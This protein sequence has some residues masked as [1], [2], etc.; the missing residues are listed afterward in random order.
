MQG[1]LGDG[2]QGASLAAGG[3]R[4]ERPSH[5]E[6]LVAVR[7]RDE[8][9]RHLEHH[10][11]FAHLGRVVHVHPR[12]RPAVRPLRSRVASRAARLRRA[13]PG[14]A[15]AG[16]ARC[17]RAGAR[18]LEEA[19]R[20]RRGQYRGAVPAL[21]VGRDE[22]RPRASPRSCRPQRRSSRVDPRARASR[23]SAS[24]EAKLA[25][26]LLG[27]AGVALLV[28]SPGGGGLLAAL[29]VVLAA[30]G[31]ACGATFSVA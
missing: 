30:F 28:G 14:R 21:R 18:S 23:T 11:A 20:A 9:P 27:L 12:R 29:A 8:S 17:G 4:P 2:A 6:G 5:A 15:L 10:R 24:A 1:L 26:V 22:D 16:A 13:R 31:Y 19:A 3:G 7:T 25:G